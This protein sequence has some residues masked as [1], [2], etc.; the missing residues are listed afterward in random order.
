ME[1][2]K[3]ADMEVDKVADIEVHMVAYIEVD[4][5]FD[6]FKTMCLKPE[7]WK[8][9]GPKF[10]DAKCTHLACLLS[11]AR[12]LQQDYYIDFYSTW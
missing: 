6:M 8:C 11:F 9:I 10:F 2:D 7:M 4:K 3:V 5:V 1:V 12:I